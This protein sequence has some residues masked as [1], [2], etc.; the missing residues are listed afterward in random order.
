MILMPFSYLNFKIYIIS[1]HLIWDST[2]PE[3]VRAGEQSDLAGRR[4][5]QELLIGMYVPGSTS[6][7][8]EQGPTMVLY[9]SGDLSRSN[10][11]NSS[12]PQS[13]ETIPK[14]GL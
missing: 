2:P 10:K 7:S 12:P 4:G 8:Q 13:R 6:K 5:P 14:K 3:S 9:R 1:R 11:T